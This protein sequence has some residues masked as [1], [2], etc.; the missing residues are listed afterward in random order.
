MA[1]S[2]FNNASLGRRTWL[3]IAALTL[4]SLLSGPVAA[5]ED[6]DRAYFTDLAFTDHN[7]QA[8]R[9]YTDMLKDKV[10]LINFVFTNCVGAC[11]VMTRNMVSIKD[12]LG[13]QFGNEVFFVSISIDPAND[14]PAALRE[15]AEKFSAIDPGW[16]FITADHTTVETVVGRLGQYNEN[17]EAHST[18]MLAANTRTKHW[19]KL[20]PGLPPEAITMKLQ[21]LLK[22]G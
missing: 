22:E 9:F 14:T 7:G 10:V 4:A 19:I 3:G 18:L 15:F 17:V 5:T 6:R 20:R 2:R 13:D 8:Q 21:E 1:Q 11:P 16:H 12:K